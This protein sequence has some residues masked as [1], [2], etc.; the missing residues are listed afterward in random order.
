MESQADFQRL[1]WVLSCRS[2]AC[3]TGDLPLRQSVPR[4]VNGQW[5]DQV[6][7]ANLDQISGGLSRELLKK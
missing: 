1:N 7:W 5:V 2:Q 4:C 3:K 6:M